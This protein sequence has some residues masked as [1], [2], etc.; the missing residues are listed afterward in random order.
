MP[1]DEKKSSVG[2]RLLGWL[3]AGVRGRGRAVRMPLPG[4]VA[5]YFTGGT[6]IAYQIG[7]ISA[8]GFFMITEERPFIGSV[9]RVT[10]QRTDENGANLDDSIMVNATVMR[11]DSDGVGLKFMLSPAGTSGGRGAGMPSPADQKRLSGF[12]KR[13]DSQRSV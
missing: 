11:W 13:L 9:I 8:T 2:A 1:S 4:L 10:L 3:A 12:M 7:D 5:Y 6:P